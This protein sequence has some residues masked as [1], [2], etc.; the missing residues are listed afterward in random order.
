M[1][2]ISSRLEMRGRF[3]VGDAVVYDFSSPHGPVTLH[4]APE[5]GSGWRVQAHAANVPNA[6]AVVVTASGPTRA[7]AL[8]HVT[9]FWRKKRT[10]QSLPAVDWPSVIAFLDRID[11]L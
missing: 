5:D 11:A 9:K 4:F 2:G 8:A 6:D 10:S 3:E 1:R 7:R